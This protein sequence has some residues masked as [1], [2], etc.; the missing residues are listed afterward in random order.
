MANPYLSLAAILAAGLDGIVN[1]KD[2]QVVAP[3]QDN[4]FSLTNHELEKLKVTRLPEN[5]KDA[6]ED[7]KKDSLLQDALGQHVSEKLIASKSIEW[8]KYSLVVTDYELKQYF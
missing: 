1:L 8:S 6:L 3:V 2:D 5:L 4:L 7:F